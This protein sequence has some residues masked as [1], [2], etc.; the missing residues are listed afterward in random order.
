M[1][2]LKRRL[3]K[4]EKERKATIRRYMKLNW[5]PLMSSFQL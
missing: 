1:E 4:E 2:V 5:G 3:K